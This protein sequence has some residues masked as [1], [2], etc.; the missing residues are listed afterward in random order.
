M[1]KNSLWGQE[2]NIQQTNK[3]EKILNKVNNPKKV[4]TVE[5]SLKSKT[6][7]IDEK[8]SIIKENVDR[9][10]G[11]YSSNTIVIKTKEEF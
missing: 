8:L 3:T 5:Q 1:D 6:I 4:K 2:F 7:S 11:G 9:I 10:L